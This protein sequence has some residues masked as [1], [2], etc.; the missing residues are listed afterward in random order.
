MGM[1]FGT[2]HF[3]DTPPQLTEICER[4]E[5][6]C[7][8]PVLVHEKDSG[9]GYVYE[10]TIA[11]AA[12]PDL[13]LKI[14]LSDREAM[15]QNIDETCDD[16]VLRS[17]MKNTVQG[18]NAPP[19]TNS[20]HL[21]GYLGQEVTLMMVTLLALESLGG[22]TDQPFSK[23]ERQEFERFISEE[24]L[25]ARC[26]EAAKQVRRS[27]YT[28]LLTLPLWLPIWLLGMVAFVIMLPWKILQANRI[29]KQLRQGD[30]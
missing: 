14:S 5:A 10:A 2:S 17:M 8:L 6:I 26:M 24:E 16:P 3:S 25:E 7:G 30:S 20:V 13:E 11:F 15:R 18:A 12:N 28:A 1:M 21:Q 27:Q 23:E 4:M 22:V 29:V 9:P 19:G